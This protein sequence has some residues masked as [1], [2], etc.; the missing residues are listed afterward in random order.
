MSTRTLVISR[1]WHIARPSIPFATRT[2]VTT[3]PH[4]KTA[5]ET[6]TDTVKD[7]AK[8]VDKTVSKAAIKGLE[9]IE[10]VNEVTRDATEKVGIKIH[11]TT[12]E[13]NE[14]E[15]GT[16]AGVRGDQMKRDAKQGV[17]QTAAKVKDA[18][19]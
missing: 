7:A 11:D 17:K 3:L 19:S 5:T 18:A 13:F 2:F 10:K 16:K 6:V 12:D 15:V 8:A 1:Q 4:R 9:G 14:F